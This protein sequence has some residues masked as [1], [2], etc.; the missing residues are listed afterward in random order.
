MHHPS[1][2]IYR[3]VLQPQK[4]SR[5]TSK[6]NA[7][8]STHGKGGLPPGTGSDTPILW[9][10][11][12]AFIRWAIYACLLFLLFPSILPAA[13]VQLAWDPNS[14]EADGYHVY[15]RKDGEAYDYNTPV[16]AS[17]TNGSIDTSCT[18]DGLAE[19]VTYF[20]VVR[21]CDGPIESGDSN[22]VQYR[23]FSNRSPVAR[24]GGNQKVTAGSLVNISGAGSYDQDGE[25]LTYDVQ[26]TNGPDVD[27]NCSGA[28][29]SFT[30]P[31]VAGR[32]TAL[33]FDL[34]VSDGSGLSDTATTII[35]VD[36]VSSQG[37]EGGV[38]DPGAEDGNNGPELPALTAPANG[39]SNVQ[40]AP[41]LRTSAF[42][43][44]D[45]DGHL[46]TQWQIT[47]TDTGIEMMDLVS[48]NRYL[49]DLRVPQLILN[50]KT[51]YSA[52]VRFFDHL[53]RSSQW[54][55]PTTFTIGE[56][57]GDLNHNQIPDNLEVS[58]HTDMNDDTIPDID[59]PADIK[60]VSIANGQ[61]LVGITVAG[62]GNGISIDAVT[63]V[64]PKVLDTPPDPGVQLPLGLLN[65]KIRVSQ[66]GETVDVTLY[67]SDPLDTQL[68]SWMRYD[69]IYAWRNSSATTVM[70][71][72]G[73]V[74][75]RS[76]QDGGEEDADGLAN[77]II[78]DLSGP[79]YRNS[80]SSSLIT[81]PNNDPVASGSGGGGCFIGSIFGAN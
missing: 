12:S 64:D 19:D 35:L 44:P 80:N 18:I 4:I 39:G 79:S 76:L 11:G 43:D 22:E 27:L 74:V 15:Q 5:K 81:G 40:L 61:Y 65:F 34:T 55:E 24:T 41:W 20:F 1:A 13:Q 8:R 60:S 33:I 38:G 63:S 57:S 71:A 75:E 53:G 49:T 46:L 52:R 67:L 28:Q 14:P 25:S 6:T 54:S 77:G 2:C 48:I 23:T 47:E 69:S 45:G 37:G 3:T 59:Q 31:N 9:R 62:N 78:I 73:F 32:T 16:W 68:A 21:A 42:S 58:E 51:Q 30:A 10:Q 26:Q 56:D 36:P 72:Q 66:P 17:D 70:D 7:S 29:C 50:P